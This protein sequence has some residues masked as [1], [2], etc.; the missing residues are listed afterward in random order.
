M[1][2][3]SAKLVKELRDKT[4]AGMTDCKKALEQSGGDIEKAIEYLRKQGAAI[5]AKRADRE[6]KEGAIAIA[7]TPDDKR[8]AMVEVNCET[9]FV[10]RNEGFL[11]FANA[12]AN[13]ALQRKIATVE[14]LSAVQLDAEFDNLPIAQAIEMMTGKLGEKIV[15]SRL[16]LLEAT[17]GVISSYLHPGSR[18]GTLVHLTGVNGNNGSIAKE[19][20]MQV[21]AA[22]PL[23]LTRADLPKETIEKETEI[24]REQA[25]NEGKPPQVIERIVSGRLEKFYQEVV[26][27]D[28]PFFKDSDK[29]IADLLKEAGAVEV[30][31]FVRFQLGER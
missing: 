7:K 24:L 5:A 30:K 22:A 16:A 19:I 8:A 27:L 26:L 31:R 3:I 1:A 6:A 23:A 20:A 15:V 12:V 28:Q 18:L 10:A 29:T 14:A 9:D 4:G 2:E 17:D 25:K 21:A 11:R 13:A